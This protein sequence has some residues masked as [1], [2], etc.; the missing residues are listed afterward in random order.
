MGL[1][2][3]SCKHLMVLVVGL[4][5]TGQMSLAAGAAVDG[6]R[7]GKGPRRTTSCAPRRSSSTRAPRPARSTGARPRPSPKTSTPC[8]HSPGALIF[9]TALPR[10]RNRHS[11]ARVS[12]ALACSSP[13]TSCDRPR[14]RADRS[15]RRASRRTRACGT[16]TRGREARPAFRQSR[17]RSAAGRRARVRRVESIVGPRRVVEPRRAQ[18]AALL[19]GL[20]RRMK[21]R[22]TREVRG[23]TRRPSS[24]PLA[25]GVGD[26]A[27]V[28]RL[29]AALGDQ[30][31]LELCLAVGRLEVV[32]AGQR[33]VRLR[34]ARVSPREPVAT[35]TRQAS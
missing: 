15:R 31:F 14:S 26:A 17:D 23:A 13:R 22:R 34:R 24:S 4:A 19:A 3:E 35:R 32:V 6:G 9:A 33:R 5:R 8:D 11:R 28:R 27:L 1:Q 10:S 29:G 25:L 20:E 21:R 7:H 30:R 2:G 16:R 12:S 18:V